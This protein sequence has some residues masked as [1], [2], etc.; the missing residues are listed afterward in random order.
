MIKVL[1]TPKI[2]LIIFLSSLSLNL[3]S[4][5]CF[6]IKSIEFDSDTYDLACADVYNFLIEDPYFYS[7]KS[8]N[9]VYL[10]MKNE[11]KKERTF[12]CGLFGLSNKVAKNIY[13]H[14]K[15]EIGVIISSMKNDLEISH[16]TNYVIKSMVCD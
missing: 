5:S 2:I 14:E 3:W 8:K 16:G 7:L 11:S 4:N 9:K 10:G 12:I 13:F 6:R 1:S 15:N